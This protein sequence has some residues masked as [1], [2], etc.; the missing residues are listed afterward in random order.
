MIKNIIFDLGNVLL[1][2]KTVTTDVY[3]AKILCILKKTA[4][5]FYENYRKQAVSGLISFYKLTGLFKKRFNSRKTIKKIIKEYQSLYIN[6]VKNVNEELINLIKKLK[7][8]YKLY[9]MTNTLKPHYDH[10]KTF[11]LDKHFQ[12]IFRSDKDHF[13]KP[14]LNSYRLVVK[15]IKA[16]PE[17]CVFIDDLEENIKGAKTVGIKGIVY[18]NNGQ[19]KQDLEKIG[20]II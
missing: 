9:I 13:I 12:R 19:L 1:D 17:E 5:R 7:N 8:K 11:C 15:E 14:E 16:K 3:F 6:D 4:K 10:W 2:Q 20:V 18:K